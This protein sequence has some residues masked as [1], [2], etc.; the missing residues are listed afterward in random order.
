M[1]HRIPTALRDRAAALVRVLRLLP[2][3]GLAL[4]VT[5]GGC[6][7]LLGL[8][9]VV[10]VVETAAMV[11]HVPAALAAGGS[12][13]AHELVVTFLA[14]AGAF[15]GQ[16][17][18]AQVHLSLAEILARRVDGRIFDRLMAASLAGPGIGVLEDQRLLD[19]LSEASREVEHGYQSPGRACGGVVA[20][21]ARYTQ[22]LG[23]A[24]VIAVR[25]SWLVAF[26][27]LAAT[28]LF[29]HA[30][31]GGL[32]TYS[33]IF[34]GLA[35]RWRKTVYLRQVALHAAA[36]KEI[37]V[38]GLIDWLKEQQRDSYI[39]WMMPVW[40]ARRRVYLKPYLWYTAVAFCTVAAAFAALSV[41]AARHTVDLA[42]LALVAQAMLAAIRLGDF[43]PEA[44]VQ[45]QFG[46]NA[47]DAVEAFAHEAESF[48]RDT[49]V[50]SAAEPVI[51]KSAAAE[52]AA[53][54]L[55]PDNPPPEQA[56]LRFE[57]VRFTYPGRR[58]PVIDGL[59]LTI[60]AGRCT[61]IVGLN[62]AGKTTLVKLLTRLYEPTAGQIRF[63][64]MPISALPLDEWRRTVGVV[65]Q[66]FLRYDDS[67][68]RNIGYG[69][70]DHLSDREGIRH[71]ARAAGIGDHLDR[72]PRGLDTPLARHL[73][74]G[75][76]LSGGQWQRIAIARA[77]FSVAHGA[78]ILVLDEPT[79]ALDIR[80]ESR[81]Y[82]HVIEVTRGVTTILISH[83]FATVRQADEIVV[84]EGGRVRE[85]GSHQDLVRQSGRYAEMFHVQ[86]QRFA[87]ADED[88]ATESAGP[89]ETVA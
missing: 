85:R 86:A 68:A 1:F 30:Q 59:D 87:E 57:G 27:I 32:R 17:I 69:A 70:V 64:G 42:D 55:R 2:D 40:A 19:L 21:L 44:D 89:W 25:Y 84:L 28:L 65:F 6:D 80:A 72:L 67:A 62:G 7:L 22:L 63:G 12:R 82:E 66:D 46:M 26:G 43:Y 11:G 48:G 75:V 54:A 58:R 8:L 3:G 34:P 83:R 39:E 74:G 88:A 23:C 9:P 41:S 14:A 49:G 33:R 4:V 52:S 37:R 51:A 50:T 35:L 5:L 15:T 71:A 76:E 38:F 81:F 61:A 36:A 13:S 78:S 79:A 47:H 60:Q 24:V 45:T 10:F 20:L 16:Q 77:L 73:E 56:E 53:A 18:L 31:R 29:R